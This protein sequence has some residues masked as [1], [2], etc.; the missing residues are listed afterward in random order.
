MGERCSS[1]AKLAKHA[2][3]FV[4]PAEASRLGAV[5]GDMLELEGPGGAIALPVEIDDSVPPSAVFVP[6]AY[7][8][9]GVNRLGAPKGAGLRVKARKAATAAKAGA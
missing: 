9:A 7:A 1:L 5:A 2:R 6:Y 8:E 3:V 4:S